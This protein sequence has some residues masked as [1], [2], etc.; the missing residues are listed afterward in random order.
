MGVTLGAIFLLVFTIGI[1]VFLNQRKISKAVQKL[2]AKVS[3]LKSE[4]RDPM[5]YNFRRN[6]SPAEL[7]ALPQT[8]ELA[9]RV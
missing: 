9:N 7:D 4:N 3:A 6:S 5:L 8:F 2:K 1:I